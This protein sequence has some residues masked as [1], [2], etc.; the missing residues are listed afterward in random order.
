M[1]IALCTH[2]ANLE[3]APLSLLALALQWQKHGYRCIVISPENGPLRER[4]VSKGIS[5]RVIPNIFQ[6]TNITSL[7]VLLQKEHVQYMYIN[8]ILGAQLIT[9]CKQECSLP[10]FWI[11]RESER[12]E[13]FKKISV[14]ARQAF[15]HADAVIFPSHATRAVYADLNQ[16]NF[17]TVANGTDI[18]G[19]DAYRSTHTKR[20]MRICYGIPVDSH[21][22]TIIGTICPRKGQVEYIQSGLRLLNTITNKG[23]QF[24]IVGGVRC[25][26]DKA[27]L[28]RALQHTEMEHMRSFFS[29]Y[30]ETKNIYDF[31]LMSDTLVCNSYIESLPR[32]IQEAMAFE[33]PIASSK[34]YGVVEQIE[35]GKSGLLH[36]PGHVGMLAQNLETL[37]TN[38]SFSHTLTHNARIRVCTEFSM[39]KMFEQYKNIVLS[40][41]HADS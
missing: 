16:N 34:T 6:S 30:P 7:R 31:F 28:H 33:L 1:T 19:I 8:T 24:V 23:I 3:G 36:I 22:I 38:T 18:C 29:I 41:N 26:K 2:N 4:C 21:V 17:Y 27:Y 15:S 14:E 9:L 39:E 5:F 12:V 11:I 40:G 10:I 25:E 20:D 13:Y 35:H 37:I 32:V